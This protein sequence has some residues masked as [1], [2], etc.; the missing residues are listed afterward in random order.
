MAKIAKQLGDQ[1]KKSMIAAAIPALQQLAASRQPVAPPVTMDEP[2]QTP[3]LSPVAMSMLKQKLKQG[4]PPEPVAPP[5]PAAPVPPAPVA[6]QTPSF[7]PTALSM[8]KAKMKQGLPDAT[9]ASPAI[10]SVM[11]KVAADN[12][13]TPP[14]DPAAPTPPVISKITKKMG[15]PVETQQAPEA[16]QPYQPIPEDKLWRKPLSDAEVADKELSAYGPTVV[17]KYS[18]NVID[19]RGAKRDFAEGIA[20]DHTTQDASVAAALYHQ[21]DHISRR[22][23]AGKAIK[24]YAQHMSVAAAHAVNAHFTDKV[25]RQMWSKE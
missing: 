4:L 8:L 14:V 3:T 1:K 20:N 23:E 21:L 11:Q 12:P 17:K 9:P 22:N 2:A 5:G 15:K 25:M 6:P 7:N 10:A 19:N 18:Q 16:E 24:H 13:T